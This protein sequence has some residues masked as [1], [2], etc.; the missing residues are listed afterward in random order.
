MATSSSAV[1]WLGAAAGPV[2]MA[3]GHLLCRGQVGTCQPAAGSP[4][5]GLAWA[6]NRPYPA[7]DEGVRPVLPRR[8][9]RRDLRRAM[10]TPRAARARLREPPLQPSPPRRTA[11]VTDPP[12]PT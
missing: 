12:R 6:P 4:E 2:R 9:G 1:S 7:R 11:H 8:Q 10:D 5:N 3:M